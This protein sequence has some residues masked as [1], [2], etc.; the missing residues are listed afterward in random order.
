MKKVLEIAKN[1]LKQPKGAANAGLVAIII[2]ILLIENFGA[3]TVG[4]AISL[5]QSF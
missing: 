3:D 4:Q 2:L 1:Y 5:Y